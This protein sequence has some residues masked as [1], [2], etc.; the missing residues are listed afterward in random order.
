MNTPTHIVSGIW[1]AQVILHRWPAVPASRRVALGF[2]CFAGG[3]LLHLGLD[4]LPHFAWIVYLPG[5]EN[6]PFHWLIK[7]G[8]L[9]AAAAIPCLLL[10]RA[11]WPYALLGMLGAILPDAEKVAAVDFQVP[12][13]WILFKRH[14]LQLSGNDGGLPHAVLVGF[15]IALI[16]ALLFWTY[17]RSGSS[18]QRD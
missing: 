2:A 6:V 3:V 14:S 12:Q 9:A 17:R 4:L 16:G 7:E 11:H 18:A 1:L 15:E 10:A 13:R 5:F 8:L